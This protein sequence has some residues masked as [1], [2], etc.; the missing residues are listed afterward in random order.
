MESLLQVRSVPPLPPEAG[1][2]RPPLPPG[3]GQIRPPSLPPGGLPRP[4]LPQ[5]RPAGP[6]RPPVRTLGR[7]RP[8]GGFQRV[9]G[10]PPSRQAL[11]QQRQRQLRGATA[12]APAAAPVRGSQPGPN[13][14]IKYH[15]NGRPVIVNT[16]TGAKKVCRLMI[17]IPLTWWISHLVRVTYR[18]ST[19]S[20]SRLVKMI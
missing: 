12:P 18:M 2:I 17:S 6:V 1:Q 15:P 7:P 16:V 10:V 3:A 11:E 13:E 19:S 4:A 8:G 20:M 5:T 9:P 14:V